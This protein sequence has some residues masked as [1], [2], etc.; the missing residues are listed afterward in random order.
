MFSEADFLK[1]LFV[2]IVALYCMNQMNE[3]ELFSFLK[4][5]YQHDLGVN[6]QKVDQCLEISSKFLIVSR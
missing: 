1:V 6:V 4:T 2:M 5:V 3:L